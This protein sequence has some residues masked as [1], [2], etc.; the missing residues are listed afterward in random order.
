MPLFLVLAW[1]C[2]PNKFEVAIS[3]IGAEVER[4]DGQVTATG[5]YIQLGDGTDF[6]LPEID[7]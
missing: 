1:G 3:Q 4:L 6:D 7:P 5:G 2:G